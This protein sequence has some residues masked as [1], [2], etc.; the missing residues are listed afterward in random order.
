MVKVCNIEGGMDSSKLMIRIS[1]KSFFAV[2]ASWNVQV[3]K[4][5]LEM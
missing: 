1:F 2:A 3:A 5:G 4:F